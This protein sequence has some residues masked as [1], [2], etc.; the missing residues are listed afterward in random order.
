MLIQKRVRIRVKT[1]VW[2]LKRFYRNLKQIAVNVAT[3]TIR[4]ISLDNDDFELEEQFKMMF[5]GLLG[6][7]VIVIAVFIAFLEGGN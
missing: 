6:A 5:G 3:K 2:N 7:G 1:K 4:A